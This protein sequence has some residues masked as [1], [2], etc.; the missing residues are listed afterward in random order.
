LN[1]V[2]YEDGDEEDVYD[3]ECTA[4]GMLLSAA[5]I[6]IPAPPHKAEKK[7]NA[8]CHDAPA[9]PASPA[10][11]C[12]PPDRSQL[13]PPQLLKPNNKPHAK[14]VVTSTSLLSRRKVQTKFPTQLPLPRVEYITN[15]LAGPAKSNVNRASGKVQRETIDSLVNRPLK[16]P[17]RI[18]RAISKGL[19][20][21]STSAVETKKASMKKRARTK[22]EL[23]RSR[24]PMRRRKRDTDILNHEE[25]K[26]V[27]CMHVPMNVPITPQQ[28]RPAAAGTLSVLQHKQRSYFTTVEPRVVKDELFRD[29]EKEL[30]ENRQGRSDHDCVEAVKLKWTS[31]LR[32]RGCYNSKTF[33][34]AWREA[35]SRVEDTGTLGIPTIAHV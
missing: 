13:P 28:K 32:S 1:H 33:D 3:D 4:T 10:A 11:S 27:T 12:S 16:S 15:S 25:A 17:A 5:G 2:V 8:F 35:I 21:N 29:L 6:R 31:D 30:N 24:S 26:P 7:E 22:A 34:R 18:Q 14:M 20:H 19:P 23:T 9:H